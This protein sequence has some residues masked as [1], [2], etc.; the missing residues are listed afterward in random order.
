MV[1]QV[2]IFFILFS[3]TAMLFSQGTDTG[4]DL[5]EPPAELSA[6][7]N[8]KSAQVG[9]TVLLTLR[10]TIP[11]NVKSSSD[12]KLAGLE[13][14][15]VVDRKMKEGEMVLTLLVDRIDNFE[16]GPVSLSYID[17]EDI[18]TIIKSEKV[19]LQVLSN[20]GDK[21]ADAQ[22]KPIMDIVPVKPL[23]LKYFPWIAGGLLLLLAAAGFFWWRK[24]RKRNLE[25]IKA[26]K[27]PHVVAQEEINKLVSKNLFEKGQYKEFYFRLS[28][29]LRQYIERIRNFPA[30]EYT[31]EEISRYLKN[32]EDR[33]LLPLLREAD[34]VK[35]ADKVPTSARKEE[36][37]KSAMAYIKRTA[38]QPSD[39]QIP[40]SNSGGAV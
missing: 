5:L 6:S 10:Y 8:R 39:G 19:S 24:I 2:Y 14:F 23:W 28:E 29:I 18:E 38:P 13:E 20:L 36:D 35:F 16:L 22:L 27:E 15:T 30:A 11:G 26:I 33:D 37:V 7:L 17:K 3:F 25:E 40:G 4:N 31:T 9:E 1:R 32:N 12:V 34:L 21:P